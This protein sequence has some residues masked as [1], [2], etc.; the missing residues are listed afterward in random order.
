MLKRRRVPRARGR[1]RWDQPQG[2]AAQGGHRGDQP[3]SGRARPPPPS[4]RRPGVRDGA[5]NAAQPKERA[6]APQAGTP[7][8]H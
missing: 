6:G 3:Q 7:R 2:G 5:V 8:S 1:C 4:P